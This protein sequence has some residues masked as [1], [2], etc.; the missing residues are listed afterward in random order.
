VGG[1]TEVYLCWA[2]GTYLADGNA[3]GTHYTA[4]NTDH[5]FADPCGFSPI[6]AYIYKRRMITDRR[7]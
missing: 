4:A 1:E 6:N 5:T 3:A 2:V 7:P